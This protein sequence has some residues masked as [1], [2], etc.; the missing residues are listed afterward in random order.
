ME[1]S[2]VKKV[3]KVPKKEKVRVY[4]PKPKPTENNW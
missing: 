4:V 2:K 1:Q 3:R